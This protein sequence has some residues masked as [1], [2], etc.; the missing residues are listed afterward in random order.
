[1]RWIL[2]VSLVLSAG[3]LGGR[4]LEAGDLTVASMRQIAQTS[5]QA[6]PW[7]MKTIRTTLSSGDIYTATIEAQ[8]ADRVHGI[9]EMPF[10]PG[11]LVTESVLIR[12]AFFLRAVSGTPDVLKQLGLTGGAWLKVQE[13]QP[14]MPLADEV[15]RAA[16]TSQLLSTFGFMIEE[17]KI[18][19]GYKNIGEQQLNG[20]NAAVY[21][22]KLTGDRSD[23]GIRI[24]IGKKDQRISKLRIESGTT[25]VEATIE[26]DPAIKI[27]A[28]IP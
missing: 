19:G 25:T 16:D 12:P 1:M 18:P 17:S 10:N 21:E 4:G 22:V 15:G 23:R 27:E 13:G 6:F 8:S 5:F 11:S 14:G 2:V 24:W 3:T 7:R 20:I 26:Y 9:V 28:P